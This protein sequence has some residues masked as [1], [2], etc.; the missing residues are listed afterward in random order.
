MLD[1]SFSET[2]TLVHPAA[3]MASNAAG[4]TVRLRIFLLPSFPDG[5]AEKPAPAFP[6]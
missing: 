5:R 3:R 4:I 1:L 6:V 2:P